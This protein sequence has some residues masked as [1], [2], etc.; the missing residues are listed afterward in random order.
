MTSHCLCLGLTPLVLLCCLPLVRPDPCG[1]SIVPKDPAVAFR[2]DVVLNCTSTC[3]NHSSLGWETSVPKVTDRGDRWVS[4]HISNLTDWILEPLCYGSNPQIIE[5]T[6]LH[7]YRFSPPKIHLGAEMVAGHQ[8]R[9]TC[10]VSSLV[11][12][13]S[14]SDINVTLSSGNSTLNKSRGS[15]AVG[16]SFVVQPMQ[17]GQEIVCQAWLRVGL[18]V[19][20][21]SARATLQVW[22]PP[23]SVKVSVERLEFGVG[24]NFTVRCSAEGNPPPELHWELPSNAS[25]EL[26]DHGRT[27]TVHSAQRA[28]NGTYRCLAQN[29]YGASLGQVDVLVQVPPRSRIVIVAVVLGAIIFLGGV[30]LVVWRLVRKRF[31]MSLLQPTAATVQGCPLPACSGE[32]NSGK[33]EALGREGPE[34]LGEDKE[35]PRGV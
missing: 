35:E 32:G 2:G 34:P 16:Y 24:A 11:S 22:A 1:L 3:S 15:P 33:G 20:S 10:N 31:M 26:S 17:H 23:H 29:K 18:Q 7:V 28:H 12:G 27:V 6:R 19:L 9:I 8:E 4:L 25:M 13:S 30:A 5:K 14:P 21:D